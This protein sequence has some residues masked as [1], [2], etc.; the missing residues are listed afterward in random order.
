MFHNLDWH[1]LVTTNRAKSHGVFWSDEEKAL[2]KSGEKTVEEL[3]TGT[4]LKKKAVKV[5]P[6]KAEEAKEVKKV[7]PK[8]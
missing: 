1:L 2:L 6:K 7:I 4:V 3:R 8:K 5:A